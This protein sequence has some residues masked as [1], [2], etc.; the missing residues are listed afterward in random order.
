MAQRDGSM[1]SQA[2][3]DRSQSYLHKIVLPRPPG[4]YLE[5]SELNLAV[6]IEAPHTRLHSFAS[7]VVLIGA[8]LERPYDILF[9]TSSDPYHQPS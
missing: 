1:S 9:L 3:V 4:R 2:R 7:V 6:L 5:Y 8:Q